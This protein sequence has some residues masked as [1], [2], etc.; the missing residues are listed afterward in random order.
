MIPVPFRST[1]AVLEIWSTWFILRPSWVDGRPTAFLG[2]IPRMGWSFEIAD[3]LLTLRILLI[4]V[5]IY[6]LYNTSYINVAE[7]F[8]WWAEEAKKTAPWFLE[9]NS[10]YKCW[11]VQSNLAIKSWFSSSQ[12]VGLPEGKS[13]YLSWYSHDIPRI[14]PGYS[15]DI[16][17]KSY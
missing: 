13:H 15:H 7:E 2:I 4:Y 9:R 6:I 5:Y 17:I 1:I 10:L 3:G 11:G 12:T 8:S 16:P 14:F